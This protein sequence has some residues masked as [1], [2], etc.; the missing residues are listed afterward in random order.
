MYAA[1]GV[2]LTGSSL[3]LGSWLGLVGA[4]AIVVSAAFRAAGEERVLRRELPG[5]D[6]YTKKVRYRLLPYVW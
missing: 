6:A 2:L 1:A 3:L 4:A 5:Y